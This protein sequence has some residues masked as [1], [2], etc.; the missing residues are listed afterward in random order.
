[1]PEMFAHSGELFGAAR[2]ARDR[3]IAAVQANP[4]AWP[5]DTI[6]AIILAA[7]T[8]EAFI[9]ELTEWVAIDRDRLVRQSNPISPELHAFADALQEVEKAQGNLQLKY[10]VAS[11]TLSGSMFEKG[12]NPYQD[13]A[14]LVNLRNDLMHVK[15]R[16]P[17]KYIKNLQQLRIAHSHKKNVSMSW[18]NVIQTDK[19]AIWA[20]KTAHNIILAVLDFI[21][22]NPNPALGPSSQFK[23]LFRKVF[24]KE[25]KQGA[26]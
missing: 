16:Q 26:A 23:T 4:Q 19:M 24:R 20:C 2:D 9:N 15:P 8:T 22:D 25:H 10:L 1:M 3:A 14:T 6:V 17:P 7:A 5:S 11:Q 21:P 12:K 18:F 13:F